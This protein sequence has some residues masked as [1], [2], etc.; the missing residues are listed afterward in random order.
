MADHPTFFAK[1]TNIGDNTQGG[2]FV[3]VSSQSDQADK[4]DTNEQS[5]YYQPPSG[6]AVE[7]Q[8]VLG[9]VFYC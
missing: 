8:P 3:N 5:D 7:R 9:G 2:A 6:W 1:G 4:A